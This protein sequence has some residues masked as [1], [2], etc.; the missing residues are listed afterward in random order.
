[1]PQRRRR[2]FQEC[3][4]DFLD[5]ARPCGRRKSDIAELEALMSFE[6]VQLKSFEEDLREP[7]YWA[8][9]QPRHVLVVH[10]RGPIDRLE[11]LT[12]GA[13]R[14]FLPPLPGDIWFIPAG[15]AYA[16][17]ARGGS[18][19]Y[20]ELHIDPSILETLA[21]PGMAL[22]NLPVLQAY[23]DDLIYQLIV[24]MHHLASAEDDL[25]ARLRENLQLCVCLHLLQLV[26]SGAPTHSAS[27]RGLP[28]NARQKVEDYVADNLDR[29]IGIDRIC[30]V[31]GLGKHRMLEAFRH[32]FGT[33]PKQY[34]IA[35]RLQR[36]MAMLMSTDRSIVEVALDCGFSSH[37]HM[38]S[39]FRSH[40]NLLPSDLR[41][42]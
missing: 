25:S 10:D 15:Q 38:T 9:H 41:R 16:A 6:G 17:M 34:I 14:R 24:Q 7:T 30:S 42:K 37:S 31:A 8:I 18:I 21:A 1:M 28:K 5:T 4:F 39:T 23:R 32:T 36:A 12:Q 13:V 19:R 26:Q 22:L 40:M 29:P 35:R 3:T 20:F 33:S 11:T 27:P 2:L